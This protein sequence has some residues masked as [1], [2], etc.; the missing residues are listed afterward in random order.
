MSSFTPMPADWSLP[1]H[2]A[3]ER[4]VRRCSRTASML[5]KVLLLKLLRYSL[6]DLLSMMFG[7]SQGMVKCAMATCGLPRG[8]SQLSSKAVQRS[9]PKKGKAPAWMPMASR[10]VVRAMG[11]SRLGS[12]L[13]A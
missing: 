11:N 10:C 4:S 12:Y 13:S 9:A 3:S 8:F 7:V 2:A 6:N 5:A 1:R